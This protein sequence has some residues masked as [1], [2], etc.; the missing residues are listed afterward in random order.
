[1]DFLTKNWRNFKRHPDLW[2]FCGFLLTFTLSVRKVLFYFPIQRTFNEYAGLYLYA[3]DIFLILTITS[4]LII[5]CNNINLLSMYNLWI[6]KLIHN[7]SLLLPLFIVILS[8]ISITWSQNKFIATY[9]ST[10][11]LEFYLLYLYTALRITPYFI[12]QKH[13]L[14]HVE[15]FMFLIIGIGFVQ[16]FIGLV[17]FFLQRSLKLTWLKESI[18]SPAIPGVAKIIL[19]NHKIIRAYGFMPHPNILGGFLVLCF[20]LL[21]LF[22]Q[23]F[24]KQNPQSQNPKNNPIPIVPR[25]TIHLDSSW[26][27]KE[28]VSL[29]ILFRKSFCENK[30]L[31]CFT[32][33]IFVL[34]LFLTFSKSAILG[35]CIAL[36]YILIIVPRQPA[37]KTNEAIKTSRLKNLWRQVCNLE[38]FHVEH[39]KIYTLSAA[40]FFVS[41]LSILK[42]DPHSIF[43]QSIEERS[44]YLKLAFN[45]IATHPFRGVGA[46]Q[47]VWRM[48]DFSSENLLSWQY[49]P[50]H[51]VFLLIWSELGIIGLGLFIWL[52]WTL[53]H[54]SQLSIV[55]RGT[56]SKKVAVKKESRAGDSFIISDNNFDTLSIVSILTYFKAILLSFLFIMVFDHYFW[57]IQQ[58]SLMFWM[59][60][61]AIAGIEQ[62]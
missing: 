33:C 48:Q 54:S 43:I 16:S 29:H 45:A 62:L 46:D 18:I 10:K 57:D 12:R 38:M 40:I 28:A 23:M 58:G 44:F 32:F 17:Q 11:L 35:L 15:Q 9:R 3:S 31:I 37:M 41:L 7:L 53:F 19:N 47:F 42:P 60:I 30:W 24:H 14:F 49:Q 25:G 59:V 50:V 5:L 8:F 1:M 39:F 6:N 4:Y 51:N 26:L 61:G 13:K 55:P 36:T 2:F 34:G 52:I 56:I 21:L 27:Q 20:I 22:T